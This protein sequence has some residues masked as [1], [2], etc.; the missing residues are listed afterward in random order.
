[1]A[2][3]DT[4]LKNKQSRNSLSCLLVTKNVGKSLEQFTKDKLQHIH[5]QIVIKLGAQ[6]ACTDQ[7]SQQFK[8]NFNR[9]CITCTTWRAELLRSHEFH[10]KITWSELHSWEWPK[11]PKHIAEVFMIQGFTKTNLNLGDVTVSLNIWKRCS[12]FPRSLIPLADAVRNCRN[13]LCHDLFECDENLKTE[14]FTNIKNLI[15]HN[16]VSPFIPDIGGLSGCIRDLENDQLNGYN[17]E[18]EYIVNEQNEVK[19][20]LT[21]VESQVRML[22]KHFYLVVSV[23]CVFTVLYFCSHNT[24]PPRILTMPW[25][26]PSEIGE[27]LTEEIYGD[28]PN[29]LRLEPYLKRHNKLVGREW[30]FNLT[31][32]K[33]ET[34]NT[35]MRGL[36]LEADMGYGKSAFVAHTVCADEHSKGFRLRKMLIAFHVC[37]F[38]VLLTQKPGLFI[39]RLT[40]M[41][42]HFVPELM[43]QLLTERQCFEYYSGEFCNEDYLGCIDICLINPLQALSRNDFTTSSK[44]IIIDAIDECGNSKDASNNAIIEIIRKRFHLFPTWIKL[45]M[46]SRKLKP[47]AQLMLDFDVIYLHTLEKRNLQDEIST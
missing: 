33:I 19:G 41:I 21:H 24:L 17:L 43:T 37:K 16:D 42:S 23:V 46:T 9:W 15:H 30:L 10:R 27:C 29:P 47:H 7:C 12:E 40:S 45:L 35:S 6:N 38:D 2:T 34:M 28:F 25:S 11:D 31:E 20:R 8:N 1:M 36:V 3:L 32:N 44:L 26:R 18:L 13:K 14:V 22:S 5:G 4:L 39:R